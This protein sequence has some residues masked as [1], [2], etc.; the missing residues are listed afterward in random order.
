MRGTGAR[1]PTATSP[2]SVRNDGLTSTPAAAMSKPRPAT[3][4]CGLSRLTPSDRMT[5]SAGSKSVPHRDEI[6]HGT[7]DLRTLRLHQVKNEFRRS[8]AAV[9]HNADRRIIVVGNRLD[10]DFRFRAPHRHSSRS[11]DRMRRVAIAGQNLLRHVHL[12]QEE[13]ADSIP[14]HQ[15]GAGIEARFPSIR[16]QHKCSVIGWSEHIK[17]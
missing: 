13:E 5:K 17:A 8:V 12:I 3:A 7:I 15:D 9:V 6:Q 10:P 14:M 1:D 4:P 16:Y 2:V 11:I